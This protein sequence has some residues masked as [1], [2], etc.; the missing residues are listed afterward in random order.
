MILKMRLLVFFLLLFYFTESKYTC[1]TLV[2]YVKKNNCKYNLRLWDACPHYQRHFRYGSE[3]CKCLPTYILYV[4]S[5]QRS[6][7]QDCIEVWQGSQGCITIDQIEKRLD[8]C[9]FLV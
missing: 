5:K 9:L 6:N 3:E 8:F 4:E 1:D 2:E 7:N